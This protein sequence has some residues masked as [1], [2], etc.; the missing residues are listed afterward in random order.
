[1]QLPGNVGHKSWQMQGE[2]TEGRRAYT[3]REARSKGQTDQSAWL[4]EFL[5]WVEE[6]EEQYRTASEAV[7]PEGRHLQD[8]LHEMEFT[9]TS[10]ERGHMAAKLYRNRRMCRGQKDIMKRSEQVVEFS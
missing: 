10:K 9:A 7:A 2:E 1:M 5:A 3:R 4:K 6:C 8:L